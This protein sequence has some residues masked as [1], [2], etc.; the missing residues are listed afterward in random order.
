VHR[1]APKIRC[2]YFASK[3]SGVRISYAP[4]G[5]TAGQKARSPKRSSL[6]PLVR[7]AAKYCSGHADG[8][9][10]A[11]ERIGGSG[12]A[13]EIAADLIVVC[14][15]LRHATMHH[16][17]GS[18]TKDRTR[19]PVTN[20][21]PTRDDRLQARSIKPIQPVVCFGGGFSVDA[22]PPSRGQS[23]FAGG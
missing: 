19:Q 7:T 1:C 3:R 9:Q 15:P 14:R 17:R 4:P 22:F 12:R 20:T 18:K 13:V 10:D 23:L 16:L 2:R 8:T 5:V 6:I 11:Q 21:S